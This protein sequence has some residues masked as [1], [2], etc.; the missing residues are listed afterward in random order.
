MSH[1]P[2]NERW[3]DALLFIGTLI[4]C[5]GFALTFC[6]NV[7]CAQTPTPTV[8][9]CPVDLHNQMP[10]QDAH[11]L[12]NLQ[13]FLCQ[14]PADQF[15]EQFHNFVF[16]GGF[17]D[18]PSPAAGP[19]I[20]PG[21][22]TIATVSGFYVVDYGTVTLPNAT[23]DCWII[24]DSVTTGDKS[25]FTRVSGTH[26]LYSCSLINSPKPSLPA[27]TIWL[28]Y[29]RTAGTGTGAITAT[30][31]L[32]TRVPWGLVAQ[33]TQEIPSTNR[34]VDLAYSDE[35]GCFYA[36]TG[37]G[38]TALIDSRNMQMVTYTYPYDP[39]SIGAGVQSVSGFSFPGAVPGMVCVMAHGGLDLTGL[40]T[41]A[42]VGV[43]DTVS[44]YTYNPTGLTVDATLDTMRISCWR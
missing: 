18:P 29:A 39:P 37:S 9:A 44:M 12:G 31:D 42:K 11:F 26:Y 41:Q 35:D 36:D 43:A 10:L 30:T 40:V 17:A 32:R 6:V 2:R 8:A 22:P 15:V 20:V 14:E 34:K 25:V 27:G 28:M 16:Q 23:R 4:V 19:N 21:D 5:I 33:Y 13:Q 24:L 3:A 38:W 7:A 1:Y